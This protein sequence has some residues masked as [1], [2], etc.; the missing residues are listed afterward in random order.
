MSYW[1]I[2]PPEKIIKI[3]PPG[4][5][6]P[7][8]KKRY[9]ELKHTKCPHCNFSVLWVAAIDANEEEQNQIKFNLLSLF[10][11]QYQTGNCPDHPKPP[12]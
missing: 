5:F 10:E 7:G 2:W 9:H 8:S 4:Y 12:I 1:V 11:N 3:L 6:S